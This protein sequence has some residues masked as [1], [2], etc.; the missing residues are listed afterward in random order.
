MKSGG[1]V[2]QIDREIFF[3]PSTVVLK[4]VSAPTLSRVPGAPPELAGLA[5]VDGEVM[6][7]IDARPV[8]ARIAPAMPVRRASMSAMLVCN[9]F[10]E[11]VGLLGIDVLATGSFER[12]SYGVRFGEREASL[13]DAS[14]IVAAL[15][16]T[17]LIPERARHEG[18]L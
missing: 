14:P 15:Y 16:E 3:L 13:F 12:A 17:H 9:F 7:V 1:I 11:R 6:L 4:V 10:G 18:D 5:L 8:H 2:F